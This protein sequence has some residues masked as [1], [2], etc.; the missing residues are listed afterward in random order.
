MSKKLYTSHC[1]VPGHGT[2]C[3]VADDIYPGKHELSKMRRR[4]AQKLIADM[5]RKWED[6]EQ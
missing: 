1:H 3:E 4:Y 5:W 6:I 2:H